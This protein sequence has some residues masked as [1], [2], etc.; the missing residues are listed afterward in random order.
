MAT[1]WPCNGRAAGLTRSAAQKLIEADR[2][3]R[4]AWRVVQ[5]LVNTTHGRLYA[6]E[7]ALGL[8]VPEGWEGGE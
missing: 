3:D 1:R 4:E 6:I 2:L 8:P 5:D 7:A